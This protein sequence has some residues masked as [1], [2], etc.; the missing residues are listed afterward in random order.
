MISLLNRRWALIAGFIEGADRTQSTLLPECLDDCVD[1]RNQV[2]FIDALVDGLD[3]KELGFVGIDPA[4]TGRPAYHPSVHL[5]LCVLG[6]NLTR[7]IN[8]VGVEKMMEAVK[9]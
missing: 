6:Y 8:I 1:E 7:V 5:K 3:F 4:D 9:A 2:R